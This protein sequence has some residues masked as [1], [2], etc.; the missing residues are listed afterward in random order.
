M[1]MPSRRRIPAP[2]PAAILVALAALALLA[3]GCAEELPPV[4]SLSDIGVVEG[5]ITECGLPLAAQVRFENSSEGPVNT[6]VTVQAD[7]TGWYHAELPLGR[8]YYRLRYG[9]STAPANST[10]DTVAVGRVVRRLD[11]ARGRAQVTL[12]LPA[13]VESVA[14]AVK[15]QGTIRRAD[16][17]LASYHASSGASLEGETATCDVRLLRP[18]RY[19]LSLDCQSGPWDIVI[20]QPG[21]ATTPDTL[22]V[23]L[24]D[25]A[26]YSVDFRP[27]YATLAGRVSGCPGVDPDSYQVE[28]WNLTGNRIAAAF[29]RDDGTYRLAALNPEP[30]HL[31]VQHD[32]ADLWYGGYTQTT[33]DVIALTPGARLDGFEL[34]SGGMRLRF[35][36]P[37][38]WLDNSADV[39]LIDPL[40]NWHQVHNY[41]E[42]DLIIG[43]L[44]PGVWRLRILGG[45]GG[46]SW[47]PQW[48]QDAADQASATPL[49]IVAGER[50]DLDITLETGGTVRG[51]FVRRSDEWFWGAEVVLHD[52]DG[53][54][55]CW[56]ARGYTNDGFEFTGVA[57]G[58]Y[59]LGMYLNSLPWWY[60]GTWERSQAQAVTV[61]GSGLVEGLAWTLPFPYK[62]ARP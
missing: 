3:A 33:A 2:A 15:L 45:C 53:A 25:V 4:G 48:W 14:V 43:N 22:R 7:S 59:L 10:I 26:R 50:L 29:C 23:G 42:G 62:G 39:A 40:G 17:G 35:H 54:R 21:S 61:T 41:Y 37:G 30:A 47:Q 44:L 18:A 13:E 51:A 9:G 46:E 49:M 58:T 12:S 56:R 8:Y 36:G 31:R 16:G 57:D 11:L 28:L 38:D 19:A 6:S 32:Y 60:P 5:R 34:A 24:E 52:L 55:S 27:R 1:T 20:P